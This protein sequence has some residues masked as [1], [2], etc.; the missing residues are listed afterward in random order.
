MSR[1]RFAVGLPAIVA[2]VALAHISRA[3]APAA[4]VTT[5][6]ASRAATP[7]FTADDALEINTATIAD[8][9]D[10]GRWLAFTQSVRRDAYGN[11]YRHDADPTYVHP[12]PVRLWSVD[13]RTGQ[14][15]AVFPDKRAVRGMRWSP[16]GSQLAMLVWNNDVFEPACLDAR[17]R[18]AHAAQGPAG[19]VR[20]RNERHPLECAGSQVVFAVHTTAWRQKARDTF[21]Q[22]TAGP[23]FV[24]NSKDP[25][26]AWDDLR[27]MA[28][29][30][31]VG[32]IDVKTGAYKELIPRR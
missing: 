22:I 13:S 11:D 3:Q 9:S 1:L 4:P 14:R 26:L 28:N 19:K 18:E 24:Q 10:D 2:F 27:R 20:R 16:D 32:A 29:R 25:F 23:V 21:T 31:S 12:T 6:A 17:D 5:P 8:M 7:V 30:R 15:Q